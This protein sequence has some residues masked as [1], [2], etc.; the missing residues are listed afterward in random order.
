MRIVD[1]DVC[2]RFYIALRLLSESSSVRHSKTS[3]LKL[4]SASLRNPFCYIMQI[5]VKTLTGKTITL[6]VE[7]SDTI[8]NVKA[9][10]Q[11]KE[12]IPPDQQR[13]I[14]AGK[15]L[16]DGRTLSDYNI[17]KESTL[18]LVLR[19]RG[20]MQIFVK[21]LTGKTI[22]LEVEPSDTIENVKAKIQDKEGIPP[23]QQRLIF[24]GKQLE[25]GR[26]LSDYNIQKE[27]TLHL[28]LRL[29][30]G[31]QI[32]VKTLT[33]KTITLEVEPSDTIENVKAKIQDKEGIPPDQQ[34][35]IFAG[36]Q[37]EDGRTLSDY[38]IQKESTL[39]LVLRLRGG[40]QIF[41]KTLTGKT[42]TLEVE[43]SDTIENVKAKIQ[44]KEGI[45]PDQQR[46]I[47]AGKQ[48]ED[49]RTL[50]DYNIQKESTLHLVLRLRGGMQ[51]F[52]KT[53]TGKTITLEVEP[54]DTIENV[55]AKIQDKEGIPP[56]QQRLIFAGKQLEDGR[57][58]SDY[59]IQKESTLHLVLRLRGGMQIFV[60]TLTGKTI[61]LEVEPS[62]TIENVKAKIQDK[63]GIPPDQQRLIFAGKQLED[64]RTL[65]DYNIQKESTLHLVLRLRG[66]MQIF[67]K[68]LTGKTITLEV[69]PSDTIEN[70]KAKIQ[71]KEG[72]PP[73]Q[74]RL[75]FAGKQLEDGRTLSDYNIQKESTLHLV[76]RLRGGHFKMQIFVKTLTGKTITLEVEPSD[77]I[78][79][80]KAKIQ[81]KEGIPPDQQRLIFAG[82]QLEDGRTLSDYNIQKESTLHLVL[83]LRGGMQI[84]VKTLTGKTITLEVEPSDTIEN[85]KAK[86][87]DKE[88]IPPDQQRLIFAGKQL[89]DGRTLSDYNIQKE[90]TL[91]LVLRLRGGMQIFVKT[92]TGK[93][94]TLEVEPSDTIENVKAKIQDKEGIP[95]DQQR[96]IFAGKQLEDGRT[97]SDYNIQ[98]E[99]TLHLVL[100]LRGGQ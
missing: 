88:G 99:S 83:R 30:G 73:D 80:V 89:E 16:E 17:Q 34:R 40:M 3:S 61:T 84:F 1:Y 46:L 19:L 41:V 86:I 55:K 79:N 95:P 32:F 78:E 93:T 67:V 4:L 14:F 26:T 21:T 10:I 23:D 63:E 37:L 24:A 62:D 76:L 94:I 100:R 7:P 90:S 64:G 15:Q 56:D 18:H 35:L 2:R 87:Q 85:V 53:L 68:T 65:S 43:P 42:I 9:K 29:R 20:G 44:D 92:L 12:G 48:L 96:L 58:L 27:S 5:F 11:D 25:D 13:L 47:F 50:S 72:I 22:T 31:M 70:V 59:N 74:Q 36:K 49:G 98:K 81:D 82:K 75:I 52:V 66:G 91:H 6:E 71:D 33:G 54:S 28:V 45:P 97:L 69:E 38:N 60:K 39:H 51:I 77:T 8:E 57:T